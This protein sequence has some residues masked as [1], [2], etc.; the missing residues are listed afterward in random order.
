MVA[1]SWRILGRKIFV[2]KMDDIKFLAFAVLF[3][4]SFLIGIV[5]GLNKKNSELSRQNDS[6]S[7]SITE[8]S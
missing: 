6:Q 1:L 5:C 3:S 4:V 8:V 2:K 7:V